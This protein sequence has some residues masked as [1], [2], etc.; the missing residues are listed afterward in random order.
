[1]SQQAMRSWD[2]TRSKRRCRHC[3]RARAREAPVAPQ[4]ADVERVEITGVNDAPRRRPGDHRRASARVSVVDARRDA[5]PPSALPRVSEPR[6][7]RG[8]ATSALGHE[9]LAPPRR[10]ALRTIRSQRHAAGAANACAG[11]TL[12][13]ARRHDLAD[14]GMHALDRQ[15]RQALGHLAAA[16]AVVAARPARMPVAGDDAM[17]TI[18][19]RHSFSPLGPN[20]ATTGVP[21]AAAMC[22]GAEST[23]TKTRAARSA[24]RAR[25]A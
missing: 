3:A 22:I 4:A 2:C 21:I 20:S 12:S 17:D 7:S 18:H 25:A 5:S 15:R 13:A 14:R 8:S 23:P 9:A 1:M 19:G 16:A 6:R 10:V 24:P 11:Q